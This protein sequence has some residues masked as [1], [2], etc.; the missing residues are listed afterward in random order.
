MEQE[1]IAAPPRIPL[2]AAPVKALGIKAPAQRIISGIPFQLASVRMRWRILQLLWKLY[3]N[4]RQTL[5]V[6]KQLDA[7]RRK[8]LGPHALTKFVIVDGRACF[9]LYTPGFP[10]VAFDGYIEAEAARLIPVARKTN[11]FVNV[12]LAITKK[13]TLQCEHCFEWDALN[14]REQLSTADLHQMVQRFTEKGVS[15]IQLSGGEPMLRYKELPALLESIGDSTDCWLLTSGYK[16]SAEK[17]LA[18][19]K[20]AYEALLYRSI[21]MTLKCTTL[22]AVFGMPTPG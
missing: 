19:K 22:F 1:T 2:N 3:G 4:V 9:D 18:L 15:Q 14:G 8:V 5:Q 17:A 16:L 21:I 20:A 11:R 13:C 10:S 6:A 12:F 7:N